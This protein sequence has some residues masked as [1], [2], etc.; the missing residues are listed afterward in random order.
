MDEDE[1]LTEAVCRDIA[2]RQRYLGG[3]QRMA[4]AVAQ[5]MARRGYARVQ[6]SA[7]LDEFWNAA[8]GAAL[9]A[10][11]RPGALRRGVLEVTVANSAVMQELEFMKRRIVQELTRMAPN[12]KIRNLRFRIGTIG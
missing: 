1:K 9:A 11:S 12:Q 6:A 4:D 5:L 2:R 7:E 10:H 8:V 3:P